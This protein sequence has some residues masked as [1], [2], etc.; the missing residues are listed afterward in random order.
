MPSGPATDVPK[1]I[2]ALSTANPEQSGA[3]FNQL[4]TPTRHAVLLPALHSALETE[5][6]EDS[7]GSGDSDRF[8]AGISGSALG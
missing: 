1:Q 7:G 6:D 2:R 3:A 8:R 4:F 5:S